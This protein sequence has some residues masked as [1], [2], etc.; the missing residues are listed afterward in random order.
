MLP[1]DISLAI[2]AAD[3]GIPWVSVFLSHFVVCEYHGGP[4]AASE[5]P[6]PSYNALEELDVSYRQGWICDCV[7]SVCVFRSQEVLWFS[8][9][10]YVFL[11]KTVDDVQS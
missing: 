11:K 4:F 7:I 8:L 6:S 3:G 1:T 9:A 10:F 2:W 5:L